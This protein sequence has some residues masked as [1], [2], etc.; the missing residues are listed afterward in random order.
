MWIKSNSLKMN[1]AKAQLMVLNRKN[2]SNNA[3]QAEL[4]QVL[5]VCHRY[6]E[7]T[8][9]AHVN[10]LQE[11]CMVKMALIRRVGHHLPFQV[12]KL[13]IKLLFFCLNLDYCQ[14]GLPSVKFGY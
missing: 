11:Y 2:E 14:L 6:Q 10:H 12:H 7:L 13:L 1:I 9:K 4:C 8:W 3:E 5:G